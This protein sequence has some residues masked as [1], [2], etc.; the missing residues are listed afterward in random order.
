M[1]KVT[2]ANII[3]HNTI[4]HCSLEFNYEQVV[5]INSSTSPSTYLQISVY[6]PSYSSRMSAVYHYSGAW[7]MQFLSQK[8]GVTKLLVSE[9]KIL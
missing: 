6:V 4:H 9:R 1:L 8:Y 5:V 7:E 2:Q 3:G